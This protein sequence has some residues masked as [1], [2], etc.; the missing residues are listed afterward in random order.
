MLSLD[1]H[2]LQAGSGRGTDYSMQHHA[3]RVPVKNPVEE[4]LVC[5]VRLRS[6]QNLRTE[7]E[8]F[9]LSDANFDNRRTVLKMLLAPGPA[10]M[11]RGR[12]VVPCYGPEIFPRV[13]S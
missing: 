5:P 7:K 3:F 12:G 13:E 9:S 10:A 6:K 11:K 2:V 1:R 8:E 4:Q